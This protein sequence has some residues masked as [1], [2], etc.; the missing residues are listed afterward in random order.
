MWPEVIKL[1]TTGG[2]KLK[3]DIHKLL[4][5]GEE[6]RIRFSDEMLARGYP[7][8]KRQRAPAMQSEVAPREFRNAKDA[9]HN[10]T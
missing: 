7:S 6:E 3:E 4:G 1:V 2:E 8:K 10:N 5:E 9:Q